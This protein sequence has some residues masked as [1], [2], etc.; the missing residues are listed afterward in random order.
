MKTS[1][2]CFQWRTKQSYPKRFW[3]LDVNRGGSYKS[4]PVSPF[5]RS[6]VRSLV[7]HF[8]K[9]L[10][11]RFFWNFPESWVPRYPKQWRFPIFQEN[12]YFHF[13]SNCLYKKQPKIPRFCQF[14][15][16]AS[17]YLAETFSDGS[18]WRVHPIWINRSIDLFQ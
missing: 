9:Y 18:V 14:L 13:I 7:T 1:W 11:I 17:L 2:K 12:S 16:T 15:E 10:F 3:I 6:F 8:S 5:V 4:S